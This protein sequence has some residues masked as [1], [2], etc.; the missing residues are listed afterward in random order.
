MKFLAWIFGFVVVLLGALY[1]LLFT[2]FGNNLVKPYIEAEIQKQIHLP[3]HLERFSL[4]LNRVDLILNLTPKNSV[5]VKGSYS[6][7]S[8]SFDLHYDVALKKLAALEPLIERRLNDSFF[9]KGDIVGDMKFMTVKGLSDVSKSNTDYKIELRD[10]H[11]TSIIATVNEL[12]LASLLHMLNEK[13]YAAGKADLKVN[14]KN[15]T[16]H[17]LDGDIVLVTKKGELN[18]RV[19]KKDFAITLPKTHFNMKLDAV[20][21]GDDVIY[22]YLLNSNLAQMTSSG[23]LRPQP[24]KVALAYNVNIANLAVLKPIT[25]ADLRGAFHMHGKVKGTKEKMF[26]NGE[27]DLADSQTTFKAL[28]KDFQPKTLQAQIHAL[29]L[30]KL[31]YMLKQPHYAD[32]LFDMKLDIKDAN[33]KNL[34]GTVNTEITKGLLDSKYLSRAYAFKSRMPKTTF[35]AKTFTTLNKKSIDTKA[36]IFSTLADLYLKKAHFDMKEGALKSDYL[37]KID[38][39]DQLYFVTERHLKGSLTAEGDIKK[40][41]DLDFTTHAKIAGGTVDAKLHNNDFHADINQ[42]QTLDILDMLLYPKIIKSSIDADLDYNIATSKGLLKGFLSH[43]KFTKNQV[44]DLTK[45]YAHIDLYKQRF[46]G[47]I[48]AKIDK[49]NIFASLNLKSNTSSIVTKNTYINSKTKQIRSLI[50]INANKHPLVVKLSGDITKP[51]VR[52]D[53]SKILKKEAKKAITKELQKRLGK[54]VNVGGL[55]KGLF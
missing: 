25:K 49:E 35:H 43:G 29:K 24:L 28:L 8:K 3:A 12:D 51:K 46:N 11:P 1:A 13:E 44:L 30:Q 55:L 31:L 21:K 32:A 9:T 27:S 4:G 37:V 42:L 14:F 50:D 34:Q 20:L 41:K 26:V 48:G 19:M 2:T 36:E 23:T 6:L 38:N 53:A 18:S 7:F 45:Q 47:D 5:G 16:P 33:M 40:A 52:I 54:D 17:K 22:K 39:L 10:L 15:I